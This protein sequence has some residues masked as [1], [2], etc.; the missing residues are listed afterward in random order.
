V[1]QRTLQ[2]AAVLRRPGSGYEAIQLQRDALHG[3][4]S[5]LSTICVMQCDAVCC[6]VLQCVAVCCGVLQWIPVR[7]VITLLI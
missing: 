7:Q 2:D 4:S 5:V 6:S 1:L 3:R